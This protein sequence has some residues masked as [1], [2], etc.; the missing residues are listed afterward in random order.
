LNTIRLLNLSAQTHSYCMKAQLTSSLLTV[1]WTG[2]RSGAEAWSTALV[3]R[4]PLVLDGAR[5]RSKR[6][7]AILEAFMV[8][9]IETIIVLLGRALPGNSIFTCIN[10]TRV[11][12]SRVEALN[13]RLE[14]Q[15]VDSSV[16]PRP[17]PRR[18]AAGRALS[19][20]AA[21]V[22]PSAQ[23]TKA[24]S[25]EP[26]APRKILRNFWE[27]GFRGTTC[28]DLCVCLLGVN[29]VP[30]SHEVAFQRKSLSFASVKVSSDCSATKSSVASRTSIGNK[31]R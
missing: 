25:K 18:W 29:P 13:P 4:C 24:T 16:G 17:R 31:K 7:D 6:H 21:S 27:R 10:S 12:G 8:L 22:E 11:R 2:I 19:F 5:A 9:L 30:N 1:F 3:P 23:V 14:E 26:H 15:H 28:A 20:D